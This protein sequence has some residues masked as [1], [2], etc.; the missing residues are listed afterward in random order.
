VALLIERVLVKIHPH[1]DATA[2]AAPPVSVLAAA[3]AAGVTTRT[4]AAAS[5]RRRRRAC[6]APRAGAAAARARRRRRPLRHHIPQAAAAEVPAAVK[7]GRLGRCRRAA[8]LRAKAALAAEDA[9]AVAGGHVQRAGGHGSWFGQ[10]VRD[11]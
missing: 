8:Q 3:A 11:P 10:L 7:V 2:L 4:A 9:D 6:T 1:L 5:C